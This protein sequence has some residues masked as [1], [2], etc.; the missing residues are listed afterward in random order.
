MARR[1]RGLIKRGLLGCGVVLGLAVGGALGFAVWLGTGGGNRWLEG[2]LEQR[3]SDLTDGGRFEIGGLDVDPFTGVLL[4]DVALYGPDGRAL[5]EVGELVSDLDLWPL[6]EARVRLPHARAS[7]VRVHM[8]ADEQGEIDLVRLF[9]PP[10]EPSDE[11]FSLP[12]DLE[13]PDV[14]LEGV[15]VIYDTPTGTAAHVAGVRATAAIEGRGTSITVDDLVLSGQL[16]APGPIPLVLRGDVAYDGVEGVELGDVTLRVPHGAVAIDGSIG[17]EVDLRLQVEELAALAL[18]PLVGGALV[19]G[20]WRGSAVAKGRLSE[21]TVRASLEGVGDSRGEVAAT[22]TLDLTAEAPTWSGQ[23]VISEL[24]VEDVAPQLEAEVV[25]DGTVDLQGRGSSYPDDLSVSGSWRGGEQVIY[26]QRL[27]EVDA[28]FGLSNGVLRVEPSRVEGVVGVLELFGEIDLVNGPMSLD[29]EGTL[30]PERL[31]ALGAEGLGTEGALLANVHGD[32]MSDGPIVVDGTVR[33]A[34][35]VYGPDVRLQ[36]LSVPFRARVDGGDVDVSANLDGAGITAYGATAS[37]VASRDLTVAVPPQGPIR[38]GGSFVVDQAAYGDALAAGEVQANLAVR[39]EEAG[40]VVE[41]LVNFTDYAIGGRPGT[42]GNALVGLSGDT[43]DFLVQLRDYGHQVLDTRGRFDLPSGRLDLRRLVASPTPRSE[44]T[45][46]GPGHLTVVEGGVADVRLVLDSNLGRLSVVGDVRTE[47]PLDATVRIEGLQLDL[48]SE[49]YPDQVAGLSGALDLGLELSG[50]GEA[51]VVDALVNAEDVYLEGSVR[52]LGVRGGFRVADGRLEPALTLEVVDEP[53]AAITGSVPLQGGLASPGPDLDAPSSL[54]LAVM[55]GSF[56]RLQQLSPSLEE[57]ALPPGRLSAVLEARGPLRDPELRLAGIAETD[58]DGWSQPGRV[59]FDVRRKASALAWRSDL[60]E[61]YRKRAT[62]DGTG[63]T[64]LGDV[65]AWALDGAEEPDLSDPELYLRDMDVAA[66]LLGVPIESLAALGEVPVLLAGELVGGF[67]VTGSPMAPKAEGAVNWLE[68]QIGGEPLHGAYAALTATP[69]GYELQSS[70]AFS[71]GGL[72]IGGRVPVEVDL[73]KA[74]QEWGTGDLDLTVSGA[75]VPLSV[76]A[77]VDP[78]IRSAQGLVVVDARVGGTLAEPLPQYRASLIDG[79]L[80]WRTYGLSIEDVD[81]TLEGDSRAVSLELAA[82]PVPS[83]KFQAGATLEQGNP[84]V[85]VQGRTGLEDWVP[86]GVD[87]RVV[88]SDG[89]WL[90]ATDD[91]VARVDGALDV[92]GDWPKL[93]IDGDLDVVYGRVGLDAAAFIDAAPLELDPRLVVHRGKEQAAPEKE[94]EEPPV[95]AEFVVDV[96]V[97]LKRNLELD[98]SMPFVDQL[99]ALGAAVSRVDLTTRLGGKVQVGLEGGEPSVVGEVDLLEGKVRMLRSSFE[100]TDGTIA[101]TGGDPYENALLD[102]NAEMALADATLTM[103]IDGTP[104]A[105]EIDFSSEEYPDKTQQMTML[106][107]GRAPEE[108]SAQEGAG[109]ADALAGLLLQSLFAG[110]SLGTFS[111]EPDGAVRL[112]V[113]VSQALYVASR[114]DPTNTNPTENTVSAEVE[115][116]LIPHVVASGG[117]GD[118]V[119]WMDVF[120]EVRF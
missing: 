20:D 60:R 112:G 59:E 90:L 19:A 7:G 21:L 14:T 105:P 45:L 33:Y 17:D 9:G 89:P 30:E 47:G 103:S 119:Q 86:R 44:W 110:Q 106:L 85:R 69:G 46:E 99:G 73:A 88:L 95:Y 97:D 63:A 109:A 36:R 101:F 75:G 114:L 52:Y 34:P 12:V 77:A 111:I 37:T 31:A 6:L 22:A 94:D 55:P 56:E 8:T 92:S 113:P 18:D 96:G 39:V 24:H 2:Q 115:W 108:L 87:A 84:R 74:W 54:T 117:V 61:G 13:L 98:L 10:G 1:S 93:A 58:V 66:V 26:G 49:L 53:F 76:L 83:R 102:I 80:V 29:V 81:L 62:V 43:V 28:A 40:P 48:A 35:F 38:V 27:D 118:R 78:E 51:P 32:L 79:G 82:T 120:W 16:A 71:Q 11:P 65:F 70:L 91:T 57:Q 72:E 25:L 68:P 3:L 64:R 4:R 67:V 107:T 5:V 42:D 50:T 23:V 100:L 15:Q 41:A 116:T 104:T